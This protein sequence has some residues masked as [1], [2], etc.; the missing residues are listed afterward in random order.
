[1]PRAAPASLERGDAIRTPH[2][3]EIP[4]FRITESGATREVAEGLRGRMAAGCRIALEIDA[5]RIASAAA[6]H[7]KPIRRSVAQPG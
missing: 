3:G 2:M 5:K 1:M 7:Y 6:R 4:I